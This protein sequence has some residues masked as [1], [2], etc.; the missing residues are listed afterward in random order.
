MPNMQRVI[1]YMHMF[2]YVDLTV[3]DVIRSDIRRSP[4]DCSLDIG[5]RHPINHSASW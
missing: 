4:G 2:T 1:K 5:E 3:K